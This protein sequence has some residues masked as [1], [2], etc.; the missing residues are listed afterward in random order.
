VA[1]LLLVA[2]LLAGLGACE[3]SSVR[4]KGSEHGPNSVRVGIPL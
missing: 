4:G 3:G 1:C 2:V